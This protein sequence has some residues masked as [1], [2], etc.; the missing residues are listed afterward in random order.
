MRER[1]RQLLTPPVRAYI[2]YAPFG[3]GKRAFWYR[4][5]EPR[6]AWRPHRFVATTVFGSRI[7]GDTSDILQQYI[8][9]FGV[10]EPHLTRW[11]GRRLS[12]G[13]AFI[14]VGANIGY[15]SLL[16]SKLVG[17]SGTVVSIEASPRTFDLLQGNLARNRAHNIRAVNVVVSDRRG[18]VSLFRGPEDNICLT[19][20]L[21]DPRFP[22]EC[23][24]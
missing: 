20:A 2:R 10:W 6:F 12:P 3:T 24:V 19:T 14:D 9:Y 13:D 7:A 4:V 21:G 11:I 8:Y 23:E 15:F 16:A 1:I 22:F 18:R 5:V 17:D